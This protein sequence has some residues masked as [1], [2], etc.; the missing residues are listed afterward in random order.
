MHVLILEDEASAVSALTRLLQECR[1][2]ARVLAVFDSVSTAQAWFEAGTRAPDL[3]FMDIHL[4]DGSSFELFRRVTIS[5][6]VIFTTAYD[7]HALEA[8]RVN[9][10]DYLLKPLLKEDMVR[11]LAKFEGLRH[12]YTTGPAP[13]P[14]TPDFGPL[15][16]TMQQLAGPGYK[17]SWLVHHKAKLVPVSVEDVAHFSIRNGLVFLTTFAGREYEVTQTLDELEAAVDPQR[18]FRGSRQLLFARRSVT[19]METYFNGRLLVRLA[20]AVREEIVVS[21]A[22]AVELKSWLGGI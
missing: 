17:T 4:A 2:E 20:P 22:R 1:P 9:G 14:L 6:P 21:K 11:S 8:F 10:I 19:E 12:H 3:I 7:Q 18:F 5:S 13:A 15:L 16:R